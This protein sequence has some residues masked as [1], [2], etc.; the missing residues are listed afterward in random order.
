MNKQPHGPYQE[1]LTIKDR[2]IANFTIFAASF[3]A[4]NRLG[5]RR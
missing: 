5:G 3:I 1:N 2:Q 4:M